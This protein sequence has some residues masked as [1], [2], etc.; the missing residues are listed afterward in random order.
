M[1]ARDSN[2]T[3]VEDGVSRSRRT[4]Q[5]KHGGGD[6]VL[7]EILVTV[8][9]QQRQ[10]PCVVRGRTQEIIQVLGVVLRLKVGVQT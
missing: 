4:I 8:I 1:G 6:D 2:L 10:M 7:G 9:S 3:L 5:V